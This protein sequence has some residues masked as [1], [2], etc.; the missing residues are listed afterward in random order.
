MVLAGTIGILVVESK[1]LPGNIVFFRCLLGAISLVPICYYC[2]ALR[3]DMFCRRSL[4]LIILGG[5][6]LV[7][8]WLFLFKS[9]QQIPLS[10]G[11]A[12]YH[13]KPFFI[14]LMGAFLFQ[15]RLTVNS[16]IWVCIAFI[17]TSLVVDLDMDNIDLNGIRI[18]GIIYA[19]V[20]ALLY[21]VSTL[22]VKYVD[23]VPGILIALV[24]MALGAVVIVPFTTFEALH[25]SDQGWGY[26]LILGIFNTGIMYAL[27]YSSYQRLPA[28][29]IAILSFI[30]PVVTILTDYIFYGF[31][32]NGLQ[33]VGTIL[34]FVA[35]LGVTFH[36]RLVLR[37]RFSLR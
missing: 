9:Y 28:Y 20:A 37:F 16:L 10:L 11:T 8:N 1:Q 27:S 7:F 5:L 34:I 24:Q 25:L 13:T 30:Y 33:A 12:L 22:I 17:G 21:S 15:E 32:F 6:C 29:L 3:A 26:L 18:E 14:L 4:F 2:G 31:L 36:W 23:N 19:L 35:T